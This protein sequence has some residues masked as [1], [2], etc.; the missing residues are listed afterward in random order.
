VKHYNSESSKA[1]ESTEQ[2]SSSDSAFKILVLDPQT[3][4]ISSVDA[5]A[6][7]QD[8]SPL[9]TAAKAMGGL[10]H[11]HQFLGHLPRLQAEGYEPVSGSGNVL[12]LRKV[13]DTS[14]AATGGPAINP[15]DLMGNFASPTGYVNYETVREDG[16]D[17][18]E[19]PFRSNITV[20][21]E[22]PVFS[23]GKSRQQ[24]RP[25]RRLVKRV[26]M[27]TVWVGGVAYAVG[28]LGEYFS[29][30]GFDGIGPKGF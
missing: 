1:A 22:E 18:P 30:G 15:V 6:A 24:G 27:G 13:K 5:T 11:P 7:S 3:R 12:I 10:T 19:P 14:K 26:L 23:G 21:R 8:S 2:Q 9:T 4:S 25:R 16:H 28:V 17:K 20:R 29:T